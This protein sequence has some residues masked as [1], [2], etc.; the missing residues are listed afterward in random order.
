MSFYIRLTVC[1]FVAA[2][3][4]QAGRSHYVPHVWVIC[5]VQSCCR[6]GGLVQS[7]AEYTWSHAAGW[8]P[9]QA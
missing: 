1:S 6:G 7:A 8:S 2:A 5:D 4:Q 3:I 9:L